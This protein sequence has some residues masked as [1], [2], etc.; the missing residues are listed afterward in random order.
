VRLSQKM[1]RFFL[2]AIL[3]LSL[4][5]P[6][7][8]IFASETGPKVFDFVEI[9]DF[10]GYL[11]NSGKLKD[12]TAITQQRAAVLAQ[13]I[14]TIQKANPNT[15]LLSG[16]DMFQGTPLS[17]VLKGQP[18]IEF[19]KD[20]HFDA[21]TLG[22]HE[23]DWGIESV[24]NPNSA[25]LKNS[26]IPV[27]AANV[28]DKNTGKPVKYVKPYAL[29][30]R[31]GIKIGII[32]IVDH[33][34]F[35]SIIMPSFIKNID[36]KDPAPIVNKLASELR[37]KGARIV[38]VLAHMGAGA[39]QGAISGN[40]ADF[41]AKVNGVDAIFGGHTHTV[42]TTEI[43]H[44]PVGIAGLYG[45]G[46]LDL[47]ITLN[48]NGKVS[49]SQMVFNDDTDLY[50]TA[51][52]SVD[53]TVQ[54]IVN[55]AN[56][57]VGA[58]FN[59]KIGIATND[60]TR[61][62]N[63]KPYSDS[64]LGN[65][66]AE[67]TRKA[68]NADFGVVNNGGL[69]CDIPKGDITIG[70]MFQFMPFD[71]TIVT[72]KMNPAQIKAMLEQAVQDNGKGI[73]VAGLSFVYDPN[74]PTMQ[75]VVEIK[76]DNGKPLDNNVLYLI[77][78]NNFMGAGGD[79]FLEF[80]DPAVA[81]TYTDSYKLARDIYI[82]AIKAQGTVQASTDGRIAPIQQAAAATD[83][84]TILAT[85]DIHGNIFPWDYA[86][87]KPANLGL[88]KVSSYVSGVRKTNPNTLLIDNGDTIQGTPLSYYYDKIDT[89]SEYPLIKVMGTMKYDAWVLGNHEFNYGLDVLNRIIGD[90]KKEHISVLS[91]NTFRNDHSNFVA[92]YV[93]KTIETPKG[94]VKVGILGLTTKEIPSW[95][96][97]SHYTGLQF[98]D[99]VEEANQWVPK[100]RAEG[101]DIVIVAMHSGEESPADTIPEN[102]VKAVATGV[103]GIDAIIAGHTHANIAQHDFNNPAGQ[104]VI[105][106]E[107]GRF[108]Q[109]VSQI[110]FNID[111]NA[112]GKWTIRTKS[113]KTIA[114]NDSIAA[115]P[116]IIELA[117]PYQDAT[118]AYIGTKIGT[119]QGDF[120]GDDQLTK[121]TALMDLINKVQKF[122]A[123]TDLS[124][125]APL[126]SS[127]R[128][129]K[130]DVTI[131]DLMAVYVYE[132]YLYG[133]KITGKQLKDWMEWSV[134]Y[135]AGV[136][137]PN[138]PITKDKALNIPDYNLD[139]LY[140]ATYTIDL[141]KPA[142]QRIQNLAVNHKP[143][144]DQDVF[145]VAINNYRFNGGGGFTKAAGIT[146]PEVVFD[147]A[148]S[149]GDDGQV[150]NL[151]INY[152]RDHKIIEPTVNRDWQI[153]IGRASD[154]GQ[155]TKQSV[156][157]KPAA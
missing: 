55:K 27:L 74:R 17:N 59:K 6:A 39:N 85:S 40:L 80:T 117:K 46:F 120:L 68:V 60:L 157:M 143:V 129:L 63:L 88:A 35:P 26:S 64:P 133:I 36:F 142:G 109:F 15:V 76:K 10:H 24:I 126:S 54:Q 145:T 123:K 138:D 50:N 153:S 111:K 14:K 151:M 5:I 156:P 135:Y 122:Y 144:K 29:I 146:N 19:M 65:W 95:E 75:R 125:A 128:I 52:P 104:T 38:V 70:T 140:G 22:N 21:M 58:E 139:Q 108:G 101:A 25:T 72:V 44:I 91:A 131:Q 149:F 110:D 32:G 37:K 42:I 3:I 45:Q 102:Q 9:T 89:K 103:N 127:A 82:D 41:A 79:G 31:N 33:I 13:E 67:V 99:L 105:V 121:E 71:N 93:I 84:I 86:L 16:G 28:Y 8:S 94:L 4:C 30:Q 53:Q 34:E 11:Q 7:M 154:K 100:M 98:N 12:G 113:S 20:L 92:P 49:T 136:S 114:M 148:K 137:S 141:T 56:Q 51:T 124:I 134:R 152:I 47:K 57:A 130:G 132:N 2:G 97:V 112:N 48:A 90:A 83:T 43:N 23:Y 78:T 106:T 66:T 73:Q 62:Q 107:P 96:D 61:S 150:R 119:A 155:A 81:K 87:A 147:S 115:D 69:R 77:A 1:F 116:S 118:L 18:V